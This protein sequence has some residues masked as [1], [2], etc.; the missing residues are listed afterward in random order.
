MKILKNLFIIFI[1]PVI[2]LY[3]LMP[4]QFAFSPADGEIY[5]GIDVSSW[6]RQIDFEKVK[7]SG[8]EIVYIKAS[9]G[10]T[11]VDPYFERNYFEAKKNGLK[12]GFYHYV[13]ARSVVDAITQARF[14]VSNVAGKT[15]DCKLAMDFESFGDLSIYEINQIGLAFIKEVEALSDKKAVLYSNTYTARTIFSGHLTKYP[16]WVAQYEVENPTPNGK[17]DTWAGWQYTSKGNVDGINGYVDRD[18]YTKEMF[19]SNK[20]IP[21]ENP[22]N[23]PDIPTIDKTITITI[24]WGDTLSYLANRYCTTVDELVRLNNI[25]NPNLIYAGAKLIIPVKEC[26][27]DT[28]DENYEGQSNIYIVKKGDTLSQIAL[29]FNTTVSEIAKMNN[30]KN[31]NLI[32]IGQILNIPSSTNQPQKIIYTIQR[33]D[34]LW[35][36]S[37]RYG[38]S[39]AY[40]VMQ[41]RIQNPNLIYAGNTLII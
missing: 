3:I 14:F 5:E 1:L 4:S 7:Q 40:L 11:L 23:K 38:V 36:I 9:E 31:V 34:T 22:E 33:G 25:K 17:W 37:R 12:V 18:K 28:D 19:L 24:Q 35:S 30:I 21:I 41:N 39:I 27:P 2:M 10:F 20:D 16:L 13:T 15:A 26:A 8:I 32:Y 29:N 6:Q